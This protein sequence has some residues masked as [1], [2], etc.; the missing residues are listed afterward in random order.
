MKKISHKVLAK[1]IISLNPKKF[2]FI[3]LERAIAE[4]YEW[5]CSYYE[6]HHNNH[7]RPK[8]FIEWLDSEI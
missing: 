1:K 2:K 8:T 4:Y 7:H 5:V 3:L 6:T